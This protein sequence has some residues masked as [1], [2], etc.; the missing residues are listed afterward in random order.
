MSMTEEQPHLAPNTEDMRRH[1]D[2]LFGHA[3]EYDDGLIEIAINTGHGWLGQLFGVDAMGQAVAYAAQKNAAG[4]NA[5]VGVALRDPD[6]PP[7]GRA[8]DSDHYATTAV[9][10]DL[11]TKAASAAAPERTLHMPP[12]FVVCTGNDPHTR[13]QLFWL[14]QEPVTD[15]EQ[16]RQLFGGLADML[17]GDRSIT[18]PGRIMRL[19]GSVAWP[20]KKDRVPEMTS[21]RPVKDPNRRY[22][23]EAIAKAYP[24]QHKVH[25]FDPSHKNDPIDRVGAKNG[26]GL[27]TGKIEDGREA[28]MHRTVMAVFFE[29]VGTTGALP[30]V[31]ELYE[32]AW[33]QYERKV[34]VIVP[35]KNTRGPEEC[36]AKCAYI[37]RRFEAGRLRD[38]HGTVYATIDQIVEAYQAKAK[39]KAKKEQPKGP[40]YDFS[41][42]AK[43]AGAAG[44]RFQWVTFEADSKPILNGNWLVKSMLPAEGMGVI[45]GRP[46]SGKTF[47]ALDLALHVALGR[48]WRGQ[49]TAQ[50]GV[51]Y[52][53]PEAGRQ[54]VNRVIGWCRHHAIAWPKAFRLS[55]VHVDLRSSEADAA[56]LVDDIKANQ[57]DC[58]LIIIDTL[59][60]AMAGGNENDV[61]DM[62]KFVAICEAIAKAVDALVLVVHHS[63]KDESKGSRGHSSLLGALNFEGEVRKEKDETVGT[64]TVTK[65]RDGQDGTEYA[66]RLERVVLGTDEDGDEVST[67]ASAEADAGAARQTRNAAP[68]GASQRLVADA[69]S[70]F[71][72]DHGRGNPSG[73]GFPEAGR[74]RVV[75]GEAFTNFAAG[76]VA[77]KKVHEARKEVS[78][79]IKSLVEKG[80]FATNGGYLWKL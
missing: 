47:T 59:N 44:N 71:V 67:A 3:R 6:T 76:K 7:F 66:F 73:T 37:I 26:L 38:T 35:G 53:T 74:V 48:P 5:Y 28:Y 13:L 12:T 31:Q 27:D 20:T 45:Y 61:E 56:A 63:G 16:H 72:D 4:C 8:S 69:F 78:R 41:G 79:A 15:P 77:D 42:G 50:K 57:P 10:G 21:L 51:S 40:E 30:S 1:L 68:G 17:D 22:A 34:A 70:Q 54:G 33:P 75:D 65:L 2:L 58:G 39:D 64:L 19:A 9:G 24:N 29:L 49:K 55:P 62:G 23:A 52:I 36:V 14:L 46:G 80:Y 18:N 60:R 11:D 43:E 32:A 25:D